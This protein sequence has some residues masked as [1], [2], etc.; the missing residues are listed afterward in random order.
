MDHYSAFGSTLFRDFAEKFDNNIQKR[1]GL[2]ETNQLDQY[3]IL[4]QN[5]DTKSKRLSVRKTQ[6][7]RI[8]ALHSW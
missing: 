2:I 6:I 8:L 4:V 7:S 5:K 3:E 1:S